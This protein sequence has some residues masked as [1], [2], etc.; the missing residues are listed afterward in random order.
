MDKSFRSEVLKERPYWKTQFDRGDVDEYTPPHPPHPTL[1]CLA[2][3]IISH[4]GLLLTVI[5]VLSFVV[6]PTLEIS[7]EKGHR[8]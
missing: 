6:K 1:P 2:P 4:K 7:H 8:T 3:W 5:D